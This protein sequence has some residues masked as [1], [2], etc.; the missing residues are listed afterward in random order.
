MPGVQFS[1]R[2]DPPP[3]H[4]L[5]YFALRPDGSAAAVAVELAREC[6]KRHGLRG[7]PVDADRLHVSLCP[8]MS[9]RGPRKGDVAVA[10]HAAAQVQAEAFDIS[11]DRLCA[12][13]HGER[14]AVVLRCA[15][16]KEPITRLR[17]SLSRELV[18]AG[19][20]WARGSFVPH[21]TVLWGRE[22][23]PETRLDVPVCWRA[24]EF[25]LVHSL[26]GRSRH[27]D[28]GKWPLGAKTIEGE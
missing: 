3:R 7:M 1:L 10:M 22:A 4:D 24:G 2:F 8:A 17:E 26:V 21:L 15:A 5:F 19:L 18:K 13:G 25:V 6:R 20:R 16:G 11:F 27:F 14:R 9:R 12:F 23:V 28:L